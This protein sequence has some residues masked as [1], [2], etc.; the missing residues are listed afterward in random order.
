MV[1]TNS[2]YDLGDVMT[3]VTSKA[4]FGVPLRVRAVLERYPPPSPPLPPRDIK[5]IVSA[6]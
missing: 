4:S 3:G 1:Y 2:I 6:S 5:E